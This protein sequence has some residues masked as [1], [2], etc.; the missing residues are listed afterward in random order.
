[1][2]TPAVTIVA[3]WIRAL[4]GVGPSIA[5]GSQVWRPSCADLP[6]A[7]TNSSRHS[8]VIVSTRMPAKPMVD[9][10][11][12]GRRGEDRRDRDGAEHQEGAEDAEREAEIADAVDDERLQRG[13]VGRGLVVP[14]T[15]QE[16]GREPDPFP[17]EEHLHQA[18]GGHQHQHGEG[19]QR[20][21]GE[22][23]RLAGVLG[24]IAPAVD[25]DEAGDR[26]HHHQHHRGQRVDA[27]RPVDL[28]GARVDE[29]EH[30]DDLRFAHC[31][32]RN[33][34]RSASSAPPRSAARRW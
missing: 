30:R 10:A 16:V 9:P 19:E 6:I 8:K 17:A 21:I 18:V 1:M 24:H 22:E 23:A 3:A 7:P 14:E 34:G 12:P 31:P 27:Q 2:N 29:L 33:R 4:T 32:R 26:R 13:G 5:S 25:V 11:M 28:Q 15:D 20:Q